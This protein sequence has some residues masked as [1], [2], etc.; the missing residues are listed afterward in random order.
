[1][2]RVWFWGFDRWRVAFVDWEVCELNCSGIGAG[3]A[4]AFCFGAK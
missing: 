4:G 1:L 3:V 2:G